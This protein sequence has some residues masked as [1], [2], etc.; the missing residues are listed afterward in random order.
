MKRWSLPVAVCV[1][2]FCMSGQLLIAQTQEV[3]FVERH[4]LNTGAYRG[5]AEISVA[6]PI[7]TLRQSYTV[8]IQFFNDGGDN[9][10]FNPDFNGLIPIPAC[11]VMFDK[12]K[13]YIE[14]AWR[15][16]GGSQ[17]GIGPGD[18]KLVPSGSHVDYKW[19]FA[20][21]STG[22]YYL[23]F[24]YF[25]AF[26]FPNPFNSGNPPFEAQAFYKNFDESELFRSNAIKIHFVPHPNG[27]GT[28]TLPDGS[29]WVGGFKNG[30]YEGQGT[31]TSP[32][33]T[34]LQG[35]WRDGKPYRTSGTLVFVDGAKEVGTWNHDGTRSGG[36]ITWKDGRQYE[37]DWK[38]YGATGVPD[39][40][41]PDSK[42]KMTYPDG[43]VD[44]GFWKD[45]KFLGAEKSP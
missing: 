3:A 13:R 35:E 45:G 23:Q 33:G 37:G 31:F 11:P 39:G 1:S 16:M 41:R 43:H 5:H 27:Q 30:Q 17:R 32:A 40:G 7:I 21:G 22:E 34:N 25:K 29:K 44:E 9:Y 38:V 12:D 6:N 19:R 14:D 28:E 42:G 8:L 15:W 26:I 18:W 24:I 4:D 36:T 10:F 20:S 2:L